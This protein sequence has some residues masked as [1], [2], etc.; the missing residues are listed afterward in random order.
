LR[1]AKEV[2]DLAN[3]AKSEFLA[4]MS[5][6]IRTPLNAILGMTEVAQA[7]NLDSDQSLC[8][9]VIG[10][11]GNNLLTLIED[12][13]DLSYIEAGRLTLEEKPVDLNALTQEA[14]DIHKQNADSKSLV[15]HCQIDTDA[16]N[17]FFG[18]QKRMRQV[19]LN[20]IGNAIKFT[21]SGEV[22]LLVT[23]PT[24]QTLLFSV[25]DSGIGIPFEQQ[26][27]IF[28]PFSQAD[29]SSTRQ[30]GGVG[31]GL[32]I[33]SRLVDAMSGQIWVESEV[34]SGSSFH[35]SIPL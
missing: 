19:L 27:L 28:A 3:R 30:H 35:V 6:E 10:R 9:D 21:A 15:L 29:T 13:L 34:G 26:K 1:K 14:L 12:I 33:C 17:R 16:P 11:A 2:A 20:L 7:T 8:L 22:K 5:H 23:C 25:L 32:A 4:V 24:P 31:L 18:D